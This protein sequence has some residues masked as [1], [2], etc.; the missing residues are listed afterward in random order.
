MITR[1]Q[2]KNTKE[3]SNNKVISMME[4]GMVTRS[5]SKNMDFT[6]LYN[7][8]ARFV[9]GNECTKK[10]SLRI[11]DAQRC[12]K[13]AHVYVDEVEMDFDEASRA[14]MANK[15]RIGNGCYKYK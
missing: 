1:S 4:Q 7:Q 9:D 10:S 6:T 3:V 8:N 11:L 5:R 13:Q 14:W 2:S 15:R 12:K